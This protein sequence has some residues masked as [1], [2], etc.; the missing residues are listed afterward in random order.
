MQRY[1][2]SI[3]SILFCIVFFFSS[4]SIAASVKE[5]Q[6]RM[7]DRKPIITKL[8][9]GG[10]V[11]ENNKGFLE[12]RGEKLNQDIVLAENDDRR[13]VYIAIARKQSVTPE[14]VGERRALAIVE[15]GEKG[16]IFQKPDGTWYKKQ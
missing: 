1:T 13:I 6:M 5:I 8:K 11:G 10:N 14:L 2:I 16:H 7:K 4:M 9:D 12:F 15:K 3:A